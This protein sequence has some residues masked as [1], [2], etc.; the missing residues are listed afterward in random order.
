[1]EWKSREITLQYYKA[2]TV[3]DRYKS[4]HN[5]LVREKEKPRADR[6]L[7]LAEWCLQHGKT[8]E[9]PKIVTE[10][11]KMDDKNAAV[12]AFKKTKAAMDK[13]LP[14]EDN[15]LTWKERLGNYKIKQSAH[16]TLLYDAP[17]EAV[18]DRWLRRMEETYDN[19]FYWWAL[20]GKALRVPQQR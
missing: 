9:V 17:S 18:A 4:K 7:E 19:F 14:Q 10:A 8:D 20:K 1:A 13:A 15:S 16:Y 3:E 11:A 12:V 5:E 6:W 2:P